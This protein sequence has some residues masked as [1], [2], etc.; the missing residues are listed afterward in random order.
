LVA[1]SV[2]KRTLFATLVGLS[3]IA[4]VTLWA[5]L[6]TNGMLLSMSPDEFLIPLL[7]QVGMTL[8]ATIP[9]AWLVARRQPNRPTLSDIFE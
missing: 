6:L 3:P 9:I 5:V 7:L 2:L 4:I 1:S 8:V